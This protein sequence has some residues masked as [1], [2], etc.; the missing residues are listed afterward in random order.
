MISSRRRAPTTVGRQS[1]Y[2][3][4]FHL[5]F[6]FCVVVCFIFLLLLLFYPFS[7]SVY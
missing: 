5:F 2:S 1:R 7:L 3:F 6:P 4:L